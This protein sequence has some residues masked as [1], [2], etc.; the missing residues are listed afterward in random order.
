MWPRQAKTRMAQAEILRRRIM[1][2]RREPQGYHLKND[3]QLFIWGEGMEACS[4]LLYMPRA[5]SSMRYRRK[6]C[7]RWPISWESK[8]IFSEATDHQ[9]LIVWY[10]VTWPCCGTRQCHKHGFKKLFKQ[11]TQDLKG[12]SHVYGGN[13]RSM[14]KSSLLMYGLLLLAKLRPAILAYSCLGRAENRSLSS[15]SFGESF[16]MESCR[17]RSR[18]LRSCST[19]TLLHHELQNHRSLALSLSTHLPPSRPQLPL[20]SLLLQYSTGDHHGTGQSFFGPSVLS[21][22]CLKALELKASW[23]RCPDE[24]SHRMAFCNIDFVMTSAIYP[25]LVQCNKSMSTLIQFPRPP[26]H[27]PPQHRP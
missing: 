13:Y 16:T 4:A 25:V 22:Q 6:S 23:A 3:R 11:S 26:C 5:S 15:H 20:G 19:A 1:K 2:L 9:A 7:S 10:L 8:T 12:I 24:S 27:L 14:K 17:M 18:E 21:S